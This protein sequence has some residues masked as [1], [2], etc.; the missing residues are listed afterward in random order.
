VVNQV[1]ADEH[2]GLLVPQQDGLRMPA[3]ALAPRDRRELDDAPASSPATSIVQVTIGRVEVRASIP[4]TR[5]KAGPTPSGT[6]LD[7]YLRSRAKGH[8][9]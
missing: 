1:R 8:G 2:R 6:R 3:S 9:R 4:P 5:P 7:E